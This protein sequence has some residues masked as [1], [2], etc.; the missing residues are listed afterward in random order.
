MFDLTIRAFNLAE[1]YRTPVYF[2]A[3]GM[4]GHIREELVVPEN[5]EVINSM[6][7][8]VPAG[9]DAHVENSMVVAIPAGND[10]TDLTPGI[11]CPMRM[12]QFPHLLN[13]ASALST[14]LASRKM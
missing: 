7:L 3:D 8:A 2:L 9:H 11:A 4:I 13:Q 10:I 6:A 14:F 1:Q 12:P 5:V